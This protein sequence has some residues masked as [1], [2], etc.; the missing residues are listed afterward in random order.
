M[1]C[2]IWYSEERTGRGRSP[3]RP[4][5][6]V[7]CSTAS[8]NRPW[9]SCKECTTILHVSS[10]MLVGVIL[11]QLTFI[12]YQYVSGWW[13]R[14]RHCVTDRAGSANQPTFH[15]HHTYQP[16][17]SYHLTPTGWTNLQRPGLLSV[18]DASVTKRRASG[19]L[20]RQLSDPLTVTTPSR[21]GYR[22]TCL[23]RWISH[24]RLKIGY[25]HSYYGRRIGNRTQ[26]FEWY[27]FEWPSVT[28][29]RSRLFTVK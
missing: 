29:L 10:A 2:Y 23:T 26:S 12:G 11:T 20:L 5:L 3:P 14:R 6:A 18:N 21:P 1:V 16:A 15:W 7:P 25:V 8:H 17:I 28:F 19:T 13:S 4:L 22:L 27:Q 24:K 9:T